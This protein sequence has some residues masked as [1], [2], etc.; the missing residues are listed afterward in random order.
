MS[1]TYSLEQRRSYDRRREK[2]NRAFIASFKSKPCADCGVCYHPAVMEFDHLRDKSFNLSRVKRH[3]RQTIVN[4]M[5]KCDVVCAN[6]H[7]MR[8]VK[9]KQHQHTQPKQQKKQLV[10]EI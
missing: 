2:E 6:C 8:T 3:S 10:F 1:K 7:R 9:R 5:S 4:E